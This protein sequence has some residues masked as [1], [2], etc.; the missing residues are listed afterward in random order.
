MLWLP[1]KECALI[2]ELPTASNAEQARSATYR[3]RLTEAAKVR[4]RWLVLCVGL[5]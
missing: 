5:A 3:L 2:F 1:A 4:Q